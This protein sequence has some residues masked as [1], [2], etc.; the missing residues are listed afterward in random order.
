MEVA[1]PNR[2]I[3]FR[4]WDIVNAKYITPQNNN[5]SVLTLDG[6]FYRTKGEWCWRNEFRLQ[7]YTGEKDKNGKEIYEGDILRYDHM[8]ECTCVVRWAYEG[9][10]NYPGF[11]MS[12]LIGQ[13]GPVEIVGNIYETYT[14]EVK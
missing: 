4:V 2:E 11:R 10:D 8:K 13:G 1:M 6:K 9:E 12:D 3:K 14:N 7:Q 5:D